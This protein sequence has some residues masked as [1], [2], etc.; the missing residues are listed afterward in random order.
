MT[1]PVSVAPGLVAVPAGAWIYT[2]AVTAIL[3]MRLPPGSTRRFERGATFPD[4]KRNALIEAFLGR[5]D[6]QWVF[7]C[8]SDHLPA[9]DTVLRLLETGCDVVGG[10]YAGRVRGE[11][12]HGLVYAPECGEDVRAALRGELQPVDWIGAGA[13]LVR[14]HVLERIAPPWFFRPVGWDEDED[15]AF[16]RKVRDAGFVVHVHGGV[17]VP[18]LQVVPL[19]VDGVA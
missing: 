8:D 4:A 11:P 2:D 3:Q 12:T 5:P 6:L 19:A 13:L 15:I 10:L 7:F 14:R 16:C 1:S 9:P 17:R 18:H